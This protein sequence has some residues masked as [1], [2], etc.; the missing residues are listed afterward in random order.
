MC[1]HFDQMDAMLQAA[2]RMDRLPWAEEMLEEWLVTM[3][4]NV[5]LLR[6][7]MQLR[8]MQGKSDT[9]IRQQLKQVDPFHPALTM[10]AEETRKNLA[11]K[12][13]FIRH[14]VLPLALDEGEE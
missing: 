12:Q 7:C 5:Q 10:D 14:R 8:A 1:D 11:M 13:S 9:D 6:L 2:N 3:P 4:D